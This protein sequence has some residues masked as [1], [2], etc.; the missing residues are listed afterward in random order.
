MRQLRK[1][2]QISSADNTTGNMVIPQ[3]LN[4]AT[5]KY[6]NQSLTLRNMPGFFTDSDMANGPGDT[7]TYDID[8]S[9]TMDADIVS[10]GAQIPE[11]EEPYST[12]ITL[13]VKKIG[14]RPMITQEMIED[15]R[16]DEMGRQQSRAVYKIARLIDRACGRGMTQL[17][18]AFPSSGAN[19]LRLIER[20]PTVGGSGYT[21]PDDLI[22]QMLAIELQGGHPTDFVAHPNFYAGIRAASWF[23]P[24]INVT[25]EQLGA[26]GQTNQAGGGGLVGTA[27]GLRFW[28]SPNLA[29]S[30]THVAGSGVVIVYDANQMPFTY[31]EKRPLTI[32]PIVD[33]E[34][35]I[36][37]LQFLT[38]F[39][40][41]NL[42]PSAVCWVTGVY[43]TYY[44][45]FVDRAL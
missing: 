7:K 27:Y 4:A 22:N 18:G 41:M 23:A 15:G 14:L 36:V 5:I 17:S 45:Q 21:L 30:G 37:G 31:L 9:D 11:S 43:K 19:S 16:Y 10:P 33:A 34:R 2:I 26:A 12:Q 20:A 13:Q 42:V 24:N 3:V 29:Y 40:T 39:N 6:I 32:K 38:R 1:L 8:V 25:Q 35:D 28:Q 44:R